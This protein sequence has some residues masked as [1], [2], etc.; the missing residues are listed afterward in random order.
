MERAL[1]D[2]PPSAHLLIG[3][4]GG[5][6][7][8][9]LLALLAQLSA[10]LH[11]PLH[12]VHVHHGLSPNADAW[13]EFCRRSCARLGVPLA[14]ER[15]DV[16]PWRALGLEAAARAAR[17]AAY[18]RH[19]GDFLVLAHHRDDQA[20]T[21]LLQLL[22]GAGVAGLASMPAVRAG[23]R[24][25][26]RPLLEVPRANIEAY[27][28]EHAIEW[29]EDES[30]T[31]PALERSWLRREVVPLI[32]RRFPSAREVIARSA[33]HL[34]ETAEL[35]DALGRVDLERTASGDGWDVGRLLAPGPARARNALRTLCRIVGAP[36]PSSARL[37]ELCRQLAQ[38]KSDG[39]MRIEVDGWA[40]LRHRGTLYL[41]RVREAPG[42]YRVAWEGEGA[43]PLVE[44]GGVLRFKPEEGR[45]LSVD[46]LKAGTVTVRVRRGGE[47]L[48]PDAKRPRRT[49]KNLFQERGVPPWRRVALPL[50]Y[51]GET[52]VCVPGVGE[53][54]AWRAA[55]GARGLI[56]SWEP[57]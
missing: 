39:R 5:L 22:R 44:L 38:A 4:S 57:I 56:V 37:G 53:E 3:Y 31:D 45:G 54:S 15:V 1:R 30:N 35:L 10:R 47:R 20:E 36:A 46:R 2:V 13:A 50:V 33:G 43:L 17:Y 26:L 52:L 7:S 29:I 8:S 40:F 42:E 27:A 49:L 19:A 9:V 32:E 28:R 6:D 34:A 41:E 16:A 12:A 55:R 24:P 11:F 51:C 14:V 25:V 23:A 21:L 48:Q 18:E